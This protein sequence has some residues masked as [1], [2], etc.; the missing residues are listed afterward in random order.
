MERFIN[1]DIRDYK[2]KLFG[3]FTFR[4]G[5]GLVILAAGAYGMYSLYRIMFPGT[6]EFGLT[7]SLFCAIGALPGAL[8][9]FVKPYGMP[10]EVFLTVFVTENY[11]NPRILVFESD[12]VFEVEDTEKPKG[13]FSTKEIPTYK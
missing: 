8:Y 2:A 7:L 6:L 11:I 5:I 3:P 13:P 10:I 9:G 4:E 1:K 12:D